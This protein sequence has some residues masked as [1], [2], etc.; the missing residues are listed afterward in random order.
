MANSNSSL[1]SD[2]QLREDIELVGEI[3]YGQITA[4]ESSPPATRR[5]STRTTGT[6]TPR[7]NAKLQALTNDIAEEIA[8]AGALTTAVMPTLGYCITED[9]MP[10][11]KALIRLAQDK[12][13]MLKALERAAEIGAGAQLGKM[14]LRWA[15]AAAVDR[16]MV[17]PD[18]ML[19]RTLRV[20]DA[21]VA[22]HE[23][24]EEPAPATSRRLPSFAGV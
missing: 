9:S 12:P 16:E 13:W 10:A 2:E 17:A 22:T 1:L 3:D 20:T 21:Y 24:E 14:G 7:R 19:A 8:L 18:A 15:V 4:A 5:T 6:R 23:F 11:S